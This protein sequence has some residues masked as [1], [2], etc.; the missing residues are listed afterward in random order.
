MNL[1]DTNPKIH[2]LN[3]ALNRLKTEYNISLTEGNISDVISTS[4]KKRSWMIENLQDSNTNP[5]WVRES[6]VFTTA[7]QINQLLE[8]APHGYRL[9]PKTG[10]FLDYRKPSN[11]DIDSVDARPDLYWRDS[12]AKTDGIAVPQAATKADLAKMGL[13]R[14]SQGSDKSTGV[15]VAV[16]TPGAQAAEI[17]KPKKPSGKV[18]VSKLNTKGVVKTQVKNKDAEHV[19]EPAGTNTDTI[20]KNSVNTK[21]ITGVKVMKENRKTNHLLTLVESEMEKAQIVMAV[22]N[23]IVEKL[24][25]DAEKIANMKVDVLGPIVDRIKAEHGL[26]PAEAF[27]DTIYRL[28]DQALEAVMHV[29][30]QINTETLKLTGDISSAPSIEQDMGEVDSFDF[31]DDFSTDEPALEPIPVEREV[32]ES[33]SKIGIVLESKSGKVGN[34]YFNDLDEMRTWVHENKNKI[35]K[36]RSFL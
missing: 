21:K 30:D 15:Y 11:G 4:Q 33:V 31:E 36:I 18:R 19:P 28:I 32:K 16:N 23:E 20:F 8:S 13:D 27:R 24:Q 7:Y 5:D 17:N 12:N 14:K 9:D 22:S 26:A 1:S 6:L 35:S 2:V 25:R 3:K 34:K 10:V 29:K